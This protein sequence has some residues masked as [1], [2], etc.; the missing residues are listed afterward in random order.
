M[1]KLCTILKNKD[2]TKVY[3]ESDRIIIIDYNNSEKPS[4]IVKP[5]TMTLQLGIL[6][7]ILNV[8]YG[9]FGSYVKLEIKQE[10]IQ[11]H[12]HWYIKRWE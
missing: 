11:D 1:C 6:T 7:H 8:V 2:Y 4:L 5:H 10:N 3:F 9:I 12:L